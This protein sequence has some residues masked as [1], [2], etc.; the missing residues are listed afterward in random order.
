MNNDLEY[1]FGPSGVGDDLRERAK[2][3]TRVFA[4]SQD[5]LALANENTR[6]HRLN[7]I[8]ALDA[9]GVDKL[10]EVLDFGSAIIASSLDEPSSTLI[11]RREAL[12]LSIENIVDISG[13][14]SAQIEDCENPSTRSSIKILRRLCEALDL[15]EQ[16]ISFVPGARGDNHLAVRLKEIG[17]GGGFTPRTIVALSEASWIVRAESRL[18]EMLDGKQSSRS[19]FKKTPI[20]IS[21]GDPVW[22]Q[23]YVLA[24]EAR[25][26]LR[27]S[28]SEPILSI[29][30]ICGKLGVPLLQS[31][32]P[33][34][35][36]GATVGS[37]GFR[38]IAVNKVG[39]NENVL[40]RRSTM[41]HELG[42][43]LW[44]SDEF[45]DKIRVDSYEDV[46]QNECSI[47]LV[48]RRANA[49]AIAFLAPPE[50]FVDKFRSYGDKINA[51]RGVMEHF[52]ISFTAARF[53]AKNTMNLNL[54]NI[55]SYVDLNP[56]DAWVTRE[57]F[58][59]PLFP[60]R[61]TSESRH[62]AFAAL[63]VRAKIGGL[64]SVDTAS[65]YMQTTPDVFE[66]HE[67]VLAGYF[68]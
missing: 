18:R 23:G 12:G 32:F 68:L 9:F 35:I 41:A 17:A 49:F 50:A 55:Q 10:R 6:G 22:S 36:A 64:I 53:H 15:D 30:D 14:T 54:Q 65:E 44:D 46:E 28:D 7:A 19:L 67:S 16:V 1:I 29:R 34:K 66:K 62:G 13:F 39:R 56:T 38:G 40:V 25:K 20:R 42:H 43:L 2:L 3:S 63:V 37:N 52:G 57:E 33:K 21:V 58:V 11:N 24:E 45:L 27:I 26:H 4:R 5:H 47:D 59:S 51:T 61:E 8:E 48:E 31:V 60:I